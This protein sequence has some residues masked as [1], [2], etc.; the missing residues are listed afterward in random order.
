MTQYVQEKVEKIENPVTAWILLSLVIALACVYSYFVNGTIQNIV[1]AKDIRAEVSSLTSSLGKLEAQ[2][3]AK[4]STVNEEYAKVFGYKDGSAS[5]RY[6]IKGS[7]ASL[8]F[9]R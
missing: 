5:T 2:Y 1:A 3:L 7:Q 9:N 4:K 6:I 8:S